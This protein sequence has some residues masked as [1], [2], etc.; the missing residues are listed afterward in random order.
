MLK[1]LHCHLRNCSCPWL[2]PLPVSF[3][4]WI[5]WRAPSLRCPTFNHDSE[6]GLF[7]AVL[8]APGEKPVSSNDLS[9]DGADEREDNLR[10][11]LNDWDSQYARFFDRVSP[12]RL[13]PPS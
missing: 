7:L 4:F 11:S 12:E 13:P 8:I 3:L 10:E 1:S 2:L 6:G 9:R 5:S